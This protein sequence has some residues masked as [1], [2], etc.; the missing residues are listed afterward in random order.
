MNQRKERGSMIGCA[1]Y[2]NHKAGRLDDLTLDAYANLPL[3][4]I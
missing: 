3:D 1:A 2:Y 4:T